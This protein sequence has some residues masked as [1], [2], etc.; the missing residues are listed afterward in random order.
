MK[1]NIKNKKVIAAGIITYFPDCG[2]LEQNIK[3]IIKQVD[4]V[5]IIDNASGNVEEVKKIVEKYNISIFENKINVGIASALNQIMKYFDSINYEWVLTLDQD[6]ICPK[7]LIDELTKYLDDNVGI[8]SPN[9][10]DRGIFNNYKKKEIF[11]LMQWTITS[12]SLTNI[13]IWKIIGG[14]DENLFIDGVDIDFGIRLN[15]NGYKVIKVNSVEISHKIGNSTDFH[16]LG[17]H[18]IV[19]NHNAV[20]KYYIARNTIIIA[21]KNSSKKI[22]IKPY[23]QVI[24]QMVYVLFFESQ[25][26]IKIK[27]IFRG[28]LEAKRF[29]RQ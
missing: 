27:A 18:F 6:T 3:S 26:K 14:F 22:V 1:N 4:R 17:L 9:Y 16:F 29:R 20:R 19:H 12:A 2:L 23:F 7:N 28:F 5:V 21:K 25:K 11:E 8:V 13:K 24:K 15:K 10:Y